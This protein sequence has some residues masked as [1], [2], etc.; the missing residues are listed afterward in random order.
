MN[1]NTD[2]R[3]SKIWF[4]PTEKGKNDRWRERPTKFE[5]GL[6]DISLAALIK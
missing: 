2:S 4:V 6:L 1:I 3:E 5:Y